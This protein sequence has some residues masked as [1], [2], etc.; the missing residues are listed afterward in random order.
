[1]SMF[2]CSIIFSSLSPGQRPYSCD[3]CEKAFKHKHHL[4]EHKRL[5]SGEKPFVCAKCGKRFSHSGSY[6]QH[7]NHRWVRNHYLWS[8][9]C[10]KVIIYGPHG[11]WL[12]KKLSFMV[13]MVN[14][15]SKSYHLWSTWSMV[16]QNVIINGQWFIK[17]L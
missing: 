14:G 12:V 3:V 5:H 16:Y 8:M 1:M 9:A 6:S 2:I 11:Q 10:Q 7:M 4:V 15:L 17:N 13:H